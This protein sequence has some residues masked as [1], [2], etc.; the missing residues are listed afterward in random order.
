MRKLSILLV[1]LALAACGGT[2]RQGDL[3]SFDLG[4][5]A[6]AWKPA[7]PRI[8]GVELAAPSWL[9]STVIHYR[10]FYADAMRRH[11]Y[12]ESRWAATPGALIERALNRQATADGGGCRLRIELDELVQVFDT[13]TASRVLLDA[14]AILVA[15]H[16]DVALAGKS[17]SVARP[18]D[19]ADARGGVAA[20]GAAVQ[21]LAGE[22]NTWLTQIIR[23]TPAIGERCK[24]A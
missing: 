8:S 5:A 4:S 12:T 9:E 11:G 13:P 17:F 24:A 2:V 6:I 16:S 23:D 18:A 10:L 7:S 22:M 3:A 20:T 15:P 21:G 19:S 14:R 1:V